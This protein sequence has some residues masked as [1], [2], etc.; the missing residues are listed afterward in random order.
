MITAHDIQIDARGLNCPLPVLRAKRTMD[1]M[2]RGQVLRVRA[3]D[4]GSVKDFDAFCRQSG[5][6]RVSFEASGGEY[7][8][9]LRKS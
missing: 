9:R 8:F 1:H 2:Q 3:T 4:A 7:I 6:E 5:N